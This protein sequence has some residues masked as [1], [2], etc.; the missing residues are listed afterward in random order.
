[1]STIY[2]PPCPVEWNEIYFISHVTVISLYVVGS[3]GNQTVE[4]STAWFPRMVNATLLNNI[5]R[6]LILIFF[7]LCLFT[8]AA[9]SVQLANLKPHY[10]IYQHSIEKVKTVRF[11]KCK[12]TMQA[13]LGQWTVNLTKFSVNSYLKNTSSKWKKSVENL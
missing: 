11:A 12:C 6:I 13:S 7:P 8:A 9:V 5:K 4:S 2:L 3:G 10:W 1:M